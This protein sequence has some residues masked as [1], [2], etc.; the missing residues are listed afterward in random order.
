V[1]ASVALALAVVPLLYARIRVRR[2]RLTL[3]PMAIA[4]VFGWIVLNQ[5]VLKA[6]HRLSDPQLDWPWSTIV[7]DLTVMLSVLLTTRPMERLVRRTAPPT[8]A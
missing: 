1:A 6:A 5:L 3:T 8:R 2:G 7:A 4:V